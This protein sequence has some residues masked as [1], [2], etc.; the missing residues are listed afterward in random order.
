MFKRRRI[1]KTERFQLNNVVMEPYGTATLS[2]PVIQENEDTNP[3][4]EKPKREP[5]RIKFNWFSNLRL[6]GYYPYQ[7]AGFFKKLSLAIGAFYFGMSLQTFGLIPYASEVI[8]KHTGFFSQWLNYLFPLLCVGIMFSAH[9]LTDLYH[10]LWFKPPHPNAPSPPYALKIGDL[11][12]DIDDAARGWLITGKTGQG[13]TVAI[14]TLM[15]Q[16]NAACN[17][18]KDK[19]GNYIEYPWGGVMLDEKGSYYQTAVDVFKYWNRSDDLIVL[20]TRPENAPHDWKPEIRFNILSYD[21]I[22]Y[23][24]YATIIMD[25]AKQIAKS[26]GS[27]GGG[28]NSFHFQT[29][30]QIAIGQCIEFLR[31]V[32][33]LQL[34]AGWKPEDTAFP[35]MTRIIH[36]LNRRSYFDQFLQQ[37]I[38]PV[39]GLNFLDDTGVDPVARAKTPMERARKAYAYFTQ[40][41]WAKATEAPEEMSGIKSTIKTFLEFFTQDDIAEVFCQDNSVEFT[42]IDQGKVFLIAMPQS[43]KT[44]RQYI[45]TLLNLFF[46]LHARSRFDLPSKVLK[47]RNFIINWRDEAQRNVTQQDQDTEI[48]REARATTVIASQSTSSLLPPLGGNEKASP[49][50]LNLTNRIH[51]RSADEACAKRCSEHIGKLKFKKRSVSYSGKS[52]ASVSTSREYGYIIPPEMLTD[53]EQMPKFAA[54]V[55]HTAGKVRRYYMMPRD[56]KTPNLATWWISAKGI[57]PNK[58]PYNFYKLLYRLGF[59]IAFIPMKIPKPDVQAR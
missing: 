38:V 19:N 3:K 12:W 7:I 56:S 8:Y 5:F 6:F 15:H 28:G 20:K 55:Y 58:W 29:M 9:K 57:A 33:D 46:Y 37:H 30:A 45:A 59:R 34:D 53:D 48:L 41:Y 14:T 52:G 26:S 31:A 32:R 13:K 35:S 18:V 27:D 4:P 36:L 43:L 39:A 10:F 51:F 42:D 54:I 50:L 23:N 44:E 2:Q 1:T 25:T 11:E 49:I 24:T 22:P 16:F 21:Y 17:G 40:E 47:K